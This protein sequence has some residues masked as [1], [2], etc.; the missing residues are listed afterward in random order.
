MKLIKSNVF[1]IGTGYDIKNKEI[2]IHLFIWCL[3]IKL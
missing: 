2:N 1:G 3:E